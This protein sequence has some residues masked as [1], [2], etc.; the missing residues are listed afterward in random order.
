MKPAT[1]H[2]IKTRLL[3]RPIKSPLGTIRLGGVNQGGFGVG[4]LPGPARTLSCYAFGY[5]LNGAGLYQDRATRAT[6]LSKGDFVLF[7]PGVPHRC[8]TAPG[9]FWDELWFEFEGPVFDLMCKTGLLDPRHPI[10]HTQDC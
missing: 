8:G 6:K 1:D 5:I 4:H 10:Y 3:L 2:T 7:F 9:A